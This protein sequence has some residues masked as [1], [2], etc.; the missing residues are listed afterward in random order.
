[1]WTTDEHIEAVYQLVRETVALADELPFPGFRELLE[2]VLIDRKPRAGSLPWLLLPIFTCEALGGDVRLAHQVAAALEVGRIAA[3]CLDEWQDQ[4]TDD[5]LWQSLGAART[6]NLVT[7]LLPLSFLALSGL[8]ALGVEAPLVLGLH[9][10][11]HRTLLH[12]CAGQDADLA[13]TLSLDDYERVAGA[14]SGALLGLGCRAGAKVAGAP[15]DVVAGYG[16]FGHNLGVVAQMWNDFEGLTGRRGKADADRRRSL[17]TL[18][19][20]GA[21]GMEMGLLYALLRLQVYHRRAAEALARCP[22][23]GHLSLFLDA[24]S[25]GRLVELAEQAITRLEEDHAH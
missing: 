11:F 24:Y 7:G 12:L 17:P 9:E 13:E 2:T 22:E 25:T 15:S 10:E 3:G 8:A 19:G 18:A 1:M 16:E 23:A 4:D 6:I 21:E 20:Q 14:K 5:A